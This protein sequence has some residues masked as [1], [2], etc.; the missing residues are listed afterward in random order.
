[1]KISGPRRLEDGYTGETLLHI[2][3]RLPNEIAA[4][5]LRQRL[6]SAQV[7]ITDIPELGTFVFSGNNGILLEATWPRRAA[8]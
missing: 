7:F 2:A 4:H 6:S 5:T 3:L 8:K 1:M